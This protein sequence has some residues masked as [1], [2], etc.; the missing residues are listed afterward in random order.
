M[1]KHEY[2]SK[3]FVRSVILLLAAMIT[4]TASLAYILDPNLYYR[5]P[6]YHTYFSEGFTTA[7]LMK[8]Y[9]ADIA[10]IGSSMMQNTDMDLVRNEFGQEPVKY[11]RSGMNI[12]EIAMLIDK[13]TSLEK[14]SI[15]KFIVNIDMTTFNSES[16]SPYDK[17]PEYLY[18]DS[19]LND[20]KYLLG[21]ETWTK[22]IPFNLIYNTAVNIDHPITNKI[23][24]TF[25]K[26]T[27][28]NLMGDWSYGTQFGEDIV[29]GKYINNL[30]AVSKQ[31]V[32]GMYERMKNQFDNV[33]YPVL[34]NNQ[35]KEFMLVLPPYSALMWYEAEQQGYAE[36]LYDFKKYMVIRFS[37]LDNVTIYDFQDY[38]EIINLNNYKDTTHYIPEFNDMM[39]RSMAEFKNIVNRD[40][41]D[42]KINNLKNIVLEFKTKNNDWIE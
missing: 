21:F 39:I 29:K 28:I 41:V 6:K 8:N 20:I 31:N 33:F 37:E 26:T 35:H 1:M 14:N 13:A 34:Q 24:H 40:N 32:N 10:I 23:V 5:I 19:K 16:S 2:T 25:S 22:F 42:T 7:G 9:P 38:K 3:K 17:F 15:D 18:D 30:E 4:I 12:D 11:T 36:E 27:D